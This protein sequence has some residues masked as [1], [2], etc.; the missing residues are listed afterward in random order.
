MESSQ[1]INLL[2]SIGFLCTTTNTI[3]SVTA[4]NGKH[5]KGGSGLS[6]HTCGVVIGHDFDGNKEF[7]AST[8]R[9]QHLASNT[10]AQWS[11]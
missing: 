3:A 7:V 5:Q 1:H 8:L 11:T 4:T 6:F 10:L 2:E 9:L